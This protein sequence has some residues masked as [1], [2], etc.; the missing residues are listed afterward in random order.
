MIKLTTDI[1][2][3]NIKVIQ[4]LKRKSTV[5]LKMQNPVRFSSNHPEALFMHLQGLA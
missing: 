2:N 4:N 5:S 1:F 3:F